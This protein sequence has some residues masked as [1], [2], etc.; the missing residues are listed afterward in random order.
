MEMDVFT[1]VLNITE[2]W[3]VSTKCNGA[4]SGGTAAHTVTSLRNPRNA[5]N[6]GNSDCLHF[7]TTY[8][9]RRECRKSHR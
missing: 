9:H 2:E 3:S 5:D 4:H 1:Y 8:T 6:A 7:P